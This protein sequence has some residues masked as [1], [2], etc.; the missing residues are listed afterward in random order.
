MA[1]EW[2]TNETYVLTLANWGIASDHRPLVATFE[3]ENK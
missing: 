2:V 1:R 3:A